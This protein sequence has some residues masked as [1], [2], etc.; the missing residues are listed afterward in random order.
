MFDAAPGSQNGY[1]NSG[2]RGDINWQ[3]TP[4]TVNQ[5]LDAIQGL[6]QRYAKDI[7]VVTAIELL[8]EPNIPG[9][10][11]VGPL[12][13]F[14]YDGW[15]RV[16]ENSQELVVIIH[17]GFMPPTSWNGFMDLASGFYFVILDT[18]HYEIFQND[19]VGLSVDQHVQ[20]ACGFGNSQVSNTDKWTIVG[21]WSG[22]LTDCAKYL[23]GR[24]LGARYDGSYPGSSAVGS[25]EGK[26]QGS[27]AALSAA[28]KSNI[29]RFIEVQIDA[30]DKKTGWLF[31]TW[32]TEGAP[33]WDMQQ[34]I[35]GGVF[36]QPLTARQFGNQCP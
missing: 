14:Y 4:G 8:N 12:K 11:Q 9:G 18:H 15:G 13:Q 28:D 19:V 20:T 31:W 33:E 26:I 7:D 16:R 23:N 36:P 35:A 1:D 34:Q 30:F 27:V 17:D 25:C 5:T 2:H 6:A 24:G 3:K 32:K 10:V 22:A 21:E 29:R